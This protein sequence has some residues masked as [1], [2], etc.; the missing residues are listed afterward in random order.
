MFKKIFKSYD[1]SL[2]IAIALLSVFG[3]IMVFSASM[4]ISVQIYDEASDFFYNK[5]KMNLVLSSVA[6]IIMAFFPYKAML[7]NKFLVPMVAISLFGLAALFVFGKVAG[8][9]LSWFVIGSRSLQPAE[10]VKLSVIIYLAAV[11]AKKQPYI[12]EFNKGVLPPLAYLILASLLVAIQPDFGT[13]VIIL[14][15]AAA[16]I[17]TSGMNFKNIF[18]LG[19]F[20][21]L[22]A[23]PFIILLKDKIFVPYRMGRIE[24]F[25]D[26]FSTEFG[27]QLSNSYI[28][29]GAG[30]LKGLGLGESV[31]KL[32]YLP[33]AHTDFIMAVIAEELGAFGVGFVILL[34]GYIVLKG[35]LIALK[36]KDAFGS[37]LAIGISAMIGIQSFINLA[38]ISGVMPLTGV[39]LPFISYGGSS[40][41]QLFIAMGILVNVSMFVN[42]EQKYKN[43]DEQKS[44]ESIRDTSEKAYVIRK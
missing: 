3:L 1:Y 24:A 20:G 30:G 9:A 31:Q 32:G 44:P 6:F 12:N 21:I 23:A 4:V 19:L 8:G 5:Q 15:I 34:L 16:I 13:A 25:L 33:E 38:G 35:I 11:Y 42:Y 37:L 10:F 2:V 41:L 18:K 28:A 40:L 7:S 27:Y 36:C 14:A 39:T 22:L 29:L 17:F 43:K 26:P